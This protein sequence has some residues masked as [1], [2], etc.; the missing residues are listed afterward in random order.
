MFQ[1]QRT[2]GETFTLASDD[3]NGENI[4]MGEGIDAALPHL[5]SQFNGTSVNDDGLLLFPVK[6]ADWEGLIDALE[7]M[8]MEGLG[9]SKAIDQVVDALKSSAA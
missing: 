7:I 3:A 9:V 2:D 4:V 6:R 5:L 8:E 1:I